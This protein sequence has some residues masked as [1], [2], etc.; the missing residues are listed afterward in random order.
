MVNLNLLKIFAK[1]S[2]LGSFSKA[3]EAFKMPKSRVSRAIARLEEELGV[4]L[5]RRTTR[6]S[7]LTSA[8]RDFHK[9]IHLLLQQIEEEV[10]A[11]S[12]IGEEVTGRLRITAPEDI[13]QTLL[14]DL[15]AL[16]SLQYPHVEVETIVTNEFLDLGKEDIDLA[17]RA[18]RQKDSTL[19]RR[20]LFTSRMIMVA[21]PDYL[22]EFGRP[23]VLPDL[24]KHRLLL[25]QD[26][27]ETQFPSIKIGAGDSATILRSD[28]FP[29]LL[30]LAT[31]GAG[32]TILPD[33]F[34]QRAIE[35]G[36]LQRIFTQ[37]QGGDSEVNLV[38]PPSRKMPARTRAFID[39]A[40]G[41]V[42]RVR[43]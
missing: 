31:V 37:W 28:S 25:F 11:I 16:Y 4:Q 19:K 20:K 35:S 1:V 22:K 26:I 24:K 29:M 6:H 9:R 7:T 8:G 33:F 32:V 36:Q 12:D 3:A 15:L 17:V 30:K 43:E 39:L 14:S 42:S 40:V 34:C 18:G 2:E 5:I 21:A 41:Q 10:L 38:F 27:F 13:A 23:M